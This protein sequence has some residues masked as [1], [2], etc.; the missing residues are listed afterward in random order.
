MMYATTLTSIINSTTD[1]G[2]D[3]EYDESYEPCNHEIPHKNTILILAYSTFF[4]FGL[5]SNFIII[6]VLTRSKIRT[7]EDVYLLNLATSDILFVSLLPFYIFYILQEWSFGTFICKLVSGIYYIGFYN[8]MLFISIMSVDR[9]ISIAYP[10][11]ST[12]MNTVKYA[13]IISIIIWLISIIATI[14]MFISF[15]VKKEH[16]TL[17]CFPYYDGTNNWKIFINFEVNI[18]GMLIPITILLYCY[19]KMIIYLKRMNI[20]NKNNEAIKLICIIVC[21]TLI[22][23]VPF[24]ISIFALSLHYLHIIDG[25]NTMK[26]I[27]YSIFITETIALSHCC[28]NPLIYAFMGKFFNLKIINLLIKKNMKK[29]VFVKYNNDGKDYQ[30]NSCILYL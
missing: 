29:D 10:C 24:N 30:E 4:F 9:Y 5:V 2:Y 25:C 23:W 8:T 7:S 18:L 27:Y 6:Y 26:G 19:V 15:N 17:E 14:P 21:L 16:N 12:K 28:I 20:N 1:E 3:Y 22:F 11:I 13:S